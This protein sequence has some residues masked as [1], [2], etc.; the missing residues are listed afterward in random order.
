MPLQT[1][2]LSE[3]SIPF[4]NLPRP[5]PQTGRNPHG[6]EHPIVVEKHALKSFLNEYQVDISQ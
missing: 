6:E 5:P 4:V 1:Y 2:E 3:R